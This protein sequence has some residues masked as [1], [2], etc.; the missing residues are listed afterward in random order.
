[1]NVEHAFQ[2]GNDKDKSHGVDRGNDFENVVLS[3]LALYNLREVLK[4]EFFF[5]NMQKIRNPYGFRILISYQSN[6]FQSI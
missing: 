5:F 2:F 6:C 3:K 1:M 4:Y